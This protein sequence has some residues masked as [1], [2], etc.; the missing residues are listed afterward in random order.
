MP[1]HHGSGSGQR[2]R[3]KLPSLT[4]VRFFAA[5]LV[6]FFHAS[7][8]EVLGVFEDP[9]FADGYAQALSKVG[10]VGVSFFFILS[11]FVLAWSARPEDTL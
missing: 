5:A 7:L 1:H 9:G 3:Q 4:G 2:S 8:P 11:G 10:F 6:F